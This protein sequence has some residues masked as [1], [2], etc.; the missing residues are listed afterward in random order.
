M[1]YRCVMSEHALSLLLGQSIELVT[2]SAEDRAGH[3]T[4]S[5]SES[6]IVDNTPPTQGH[7]TVGGLYQKPYV[8]SSELLVYWEGVEDKESGIKQL[9]VSVCMTVHASIIN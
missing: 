2:F 9:E 3:V 4:E 1:M 8:A 5:W 7:V 6:C